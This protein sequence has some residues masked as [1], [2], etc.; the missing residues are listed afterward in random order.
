M[1]ETSRWAIVA[2][3]AGLLA[4]ACATGGLR[5][6]FGPVPRAILLT[7]PDSADVTVVQLTARVRELGLSVV[8]SVPREGYLETGWYD[9]D[10]KQNTGEPFAKLDRVVKFRFFADPSQGHTRLVAEC[11][12]RLAWDPSMPP[13]DLERMVPDDHPG[14]AMLDSVL[15]VVHP[16]VTDTTR[17]DTT[18]AAPRPG[19][20]RPNAPLS[21]TTHPAVRRP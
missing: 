14:R 20:P 1:R 19:A 6:R 15:T 11:V 9:A 18:H 8:R 3:A 13:R 4:A 7:L 17:A 16:I 12:R 5:P 10:L 21:D 2:A